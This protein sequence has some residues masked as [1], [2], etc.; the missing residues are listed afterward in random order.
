MT[1]YP[2]DARFIPT[3]SS[4]LEQGKVCIYPTDSVYGIGGIATASVASVIQRLKGRGVGKSFSVLAPSVAWIER[5]CI[6]PD[7]FDFSYSVPTTYLFYKQDLNAFAHLSETDRIGVRLLPADHVIQQ[8]A[9]SLG[10]PIISTSANYS[11]DP[12][13][14]TIAE[15]D[16]SLVSSVDFVIDGGRSSTQ[17]SRLYDADTGREVVRS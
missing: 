4:L 14:A 7:S 5:H 2:L 8:L 12:V 9:V 15:M 10:Q 17:P 3:W 13:S 11:G 6:V 1:T 16:S